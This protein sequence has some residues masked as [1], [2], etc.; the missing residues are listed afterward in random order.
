MSRRRKPTRT[1]KPTSLGELP[2]A[3]AVYALC[4]GSAR[5]RYV[6]YVGLARRLRPRI[7][8]HLIGRD[9]SVA[10]GTSAAGI[11]PDYVTEVR[12]WQSGG[13]RGKH[14]LEAAEIVAAEILQPVLRSRAMT[15]KAA[16]RKLHDEEFCKRM[17][18]LFDGEPTGSVPVPSL[19]GLD[20]RLRAVEKELAKMLK[21]LGDQNG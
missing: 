7:Y 18:T 2:L 15:P 13:F 1:P 5:R 3:P 4:G 14:A 6:A 10:A 11:N 9:S 19:A 17:K 12:W 21:G 16:E 8:Q 20:T